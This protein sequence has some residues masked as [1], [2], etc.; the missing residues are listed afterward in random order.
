MK[1]KNDCNNP[2]QIK[3]ILSHGN[4]VKIEVCEEKGL[5]TV[6]PKD[7]DRLLNKNIIDEP[8][9]D[10]KELI[11]LLLGADPEIPIKETLFMKEAF[12]LEKETA[13]EIGLNVESLNFFPHHYGPYS[14]DLDDNIKEL[15]GNLLDIHFENNKKLI[16]L[17]EKGKKV[18][19][20]LIENIPSDKINNLRYKRIGWDQYGNRGILLRVY[21]DYPVYAS[22]SKIKDELLGR[23]G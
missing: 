12:L 17:T 23:D 2:K 20:K 19:N 22:K 18:A 13:A 10:P 9:L 6:N 1:M 14:K 7:T 4:F 8:S 5:I 21:R 15:E 11:L 16:K 3:K